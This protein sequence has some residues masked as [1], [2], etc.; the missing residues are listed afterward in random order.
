MATVDDGWLIE[1]QP[2]DQPS[3]FLMTTLEETVR[4]MRILGLDP[5]LLVPSRLPPGD[6]VAERP[7]AP[8][9]RPSLRPYLRGRPKVW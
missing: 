2:P 5:T 3:D 8:R 4:D 9:G 7:P 1:I 6:S